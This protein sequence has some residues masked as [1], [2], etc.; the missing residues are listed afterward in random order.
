MPKVP[1]NVGEFRNR[2]REFKYVKASDV[3]GNPKNWHSHGQQQATL[4]RKVMS[5]VGFA[6]ALLVRQ[7]DD[8]K[9][10]LL[11]GHLRMGVVG[12]S[13][14]VPAL[15]LDVS[16]EEGDKILASFDTLA[17]MADTD[18]ENLRVLFEEDLFADPTIQSDLADVLAILNSDTS[19]L[20]PASIL[21]PVAQSLAPSL[22]EAQSDYSPSFG[23][24]V[25][26]VVETPEARDGLVHML[27]D[28]G[29][30]AEVDIVR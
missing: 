14:T 28:N 21:A 20:L 19:D 8:G 5:E 6:D 15:I 2:I 10:M 4:L 25:S 11:N 17:T 3:V 13:G 24:K 1:G 22:V 12:D 9:Y 23:F 26:V 7:T 30:T 16:Q 18:N 27:E 29:Y